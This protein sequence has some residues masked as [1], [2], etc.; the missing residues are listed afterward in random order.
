[1]NGNGEHFKAGWWI[2]WS[3]L[4]YKEGLFLGVWILAIVVM[5][6]LW[7]FFLYHFYLIVTGYT[8]NEKMKVGQVKHFLSKSVKFYSKWAI[9]KE[10]N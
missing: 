4:Q 10:E 6:M 2:I 5:T 1:M 8:T 9:Y 7:L 3:Y